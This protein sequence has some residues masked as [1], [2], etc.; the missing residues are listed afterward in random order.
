MSIIGDIT[1]TRDKVKLYYISSS[2]WM[3]EICAFFA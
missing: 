2:S 1:S 3:S